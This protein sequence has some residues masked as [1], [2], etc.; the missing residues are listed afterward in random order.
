MNLTSVKS[1]MKQRLRGILLI[2][3]LVFAY[4]G[5]TFFSGYLPADGQESDD[6]AFRRFT[7]TLFQE[8]AASNTLNLHYTLQN[9]ADYGILNAPVSLGSYTTDPV[10]AKASIENCQTSLEAFSYHTLSPENQITYDVLS[11]YLDIAKKG[12]DYILYEEPL[13]PVTGIQAQLPVLLAEYRFSTAKDIDTYLELLATT[14]EFFNSLIDLERE[15]SEKGLFMSDKIADTVIAQCRSLLQMGEDNYMYTTFEERLKTIADITEKQ[16][17]EY[18]KRNRNVIQEAFLPAYQSLVSSLEELKGTGQELSGVCSLHKGKQYYAYTVAQKTGSSRTISELK[19]RIRQQMQE[20]LS[21]MGLLLATS[22][23]PNFSFSAPPDEILNQLKHKISNAFPQ[24]AN[25]N[26]AVKYVPKSMEPHLSPA[27]YLIPCIDNSSENTIYINRAHTMEDL[28]LFTTLAHEGYPGH[29]YQTTYF[30]EKEPD[31]IRSILDFGGYTE[32]WAIYAEMCSYYLAPLSKK[33]ATLAQKNSSLL[34]GL[35]ALAD[36]GIH[37]D[38][39]TLEDTNSFF[40]HYGID[41]P[42]VISEIYEL[43]I[44]DP[45][46]YLKYYV[47]YVE[48][49]ELKKEYATKKGNDFSQKEFHKSVLDVGPAPFDV[50]RKY[51]LK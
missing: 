27:F 18:I 2:L 34:L 7:L 3:G 45:A 4:L 24:S 8:E 23:I 17:K 26:T 47:G 5:I 35:Y 10:S 11:S 41:D 49:L 39:W 9:P 32:G 46:N 19:N 25:V 6:D 33:E 37:Y 43:I 36:I 14:P 16:K 28:K 12:T 31:P 15:K 44:S 1:L 51:V 29:L 48:M 13:S 20:D 42:D 38:G 40:S 22:Q 50:L 21:S 30:S